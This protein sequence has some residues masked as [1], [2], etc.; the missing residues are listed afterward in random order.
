M[1]GEEL[2]T[3]PERFL[4]RPYVRSRSLRLYTQAEHRG[5]P[6]LEVRRF[7]VR[8]V[9]RPGADWRTLDEQ[10][11]KA[12][13]SVIGGDFVLDIREVDLIPREPG[14]KVRP[15]ISNCL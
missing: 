7:L 14:G 10:L 3:A 11:A 9:K 13:C 1:T 6:R 2:E 4:S 15:I 8:A 12:D 5:V